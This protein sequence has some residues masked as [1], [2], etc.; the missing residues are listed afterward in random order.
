MD[1]ALE[2]L[3]GLRCAW[4]RATMRVRAESS[5]DVPYRLLLDTLG[6]GLEQ[7]LRYLGSERPDFARFIRWIQETAGPLGDDRIAR[8]RAWAEGSPTPSLEVAR[9][10]AVMAA[11]PVFT[12]AERAKWEAD[13][14]V[15]LRNAIDRA[16]AAAIADHLWDILAASPNDPSTW[17]GSRTNGIMIQQ[18]QHPTLEA[19]RGS[20]RIAKA[21]SEL[22]GHA[23]LIVSTDRLSFNPP[24][25]AFYRF[26]GP[27]LHWDTSLASPI[28][29]ETQAILS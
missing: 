17:Y 15:I 24:E 21:F 1:H 7:T 8:Y 29:F 27:G 13:G 23:D 4:A 10:A 5:L 9:Q 18:F 16:E 28:P 14:L 26:P 2:T 25:T 3:P 20:A 19:S 11:P 12:D 6:L 22:Y